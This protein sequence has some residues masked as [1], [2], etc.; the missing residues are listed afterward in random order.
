MQTPVW[1]QMNE[2]ALS[3]PPQWEDKTITALSFPAGS[4]SPEASFAI[5][6]DPGGNG[7][8]SLSGYVDRQVADLAKTCRK[9]S[10][11]DRH[12]CTVDNLPAEVIEFSWQSPD[13]MGVV[14][15]QTVLLLSSGVA[16]T[17]TG[18]ARR[19][20]FSSYADMFQQMVG[21]FQ[22]RK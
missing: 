18:T 12:A 15:Q 2:G 20:K 5:T 6:R 17:F 16:L 3:V 10:L 7:A 14:Q 22:V 9:F 4:R 11:I 19:E 1:F 21:S 13:G 8:G